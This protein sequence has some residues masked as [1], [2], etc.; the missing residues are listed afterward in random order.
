M[1]IGVLILVLCIGSILINVA[2]YGCPDT[3]STWSKVC[4][5]LTGTVSSLMCLASCVLLIFGAFRSSI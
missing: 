1:N 5:N 2:S 4:N 3:D